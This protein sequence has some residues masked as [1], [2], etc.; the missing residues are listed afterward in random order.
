VSPLPVAVDLG[1]GAFLRK[2]RIEDLDPVWGLIQAER[3]RIGVWMPWVEVTRTIDDQR[4]WLEAVVRDE[5]NL[6][7]L[8]IFVE[9]RYVGGV[10]ITMDAFRI[11]GDIG[12]WVGA[13]HEGRGLV[14]AAVRALIDIGFRDLGLHRIVIRAG[15]ENRRS[16][17]IPERLG[18]TREGV[19][20]GEGKGSG[21]FY[22]LV[23]YSLLEDEWPAKA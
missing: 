8:G 20:R 22:D 19:A 6:D 3:E 2:L 16:R 23:V 10:G 12:Y 17:A 21:G 7:G 18:F 14:T 13:E 15:V 4:E 5:R 1:D 11:A 9:G